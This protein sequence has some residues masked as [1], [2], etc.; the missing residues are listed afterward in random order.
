MDDRDKM[1]DFRS[2]VK[3]L[4]IAMI[5]VIIT[6][7]SGMAG[8]FFITPSPDTYNSS[9]SLFASILYI[10]AFKNPALSIH[11]VIVAILMITTGV[12]TLISIK[13]GIIFWMLALMAFVAEIMGSATGMF[14]VTAYF[15]NQALSIVMV[16]S[17]V[18]TLILFMLM[19]FIAKNYKKLNI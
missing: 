2:L 10:L 17:F 11:S 9:R 3:V 5:L 18:L 14:I 16:A 1:P 19:L 6:F 7:I 8:F 13:S 15:H 4:N 12:L